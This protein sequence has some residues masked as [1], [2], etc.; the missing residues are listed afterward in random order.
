MAQV[1]TSMYNALGTRPK[2]IGEYT[3]ELDMADLRRQGMQQ[4]AL[5]LQTG[6]MGLQDR[7]RA[8]READTIRNS[9]SGLGP[10]ATDEQRINALKSTGLQGGF[11]QADALEKAI[12]ERQKTGAEVKN[13]DASTQKTYGEAQADA[14]KRYRGALDYV[15]TPQG[16]QRW[17][18]AQYGD[19]VLGQYMA[20]TLG[21]LEQAI[22]RIPTDPQ[23]F[24]QWRQ[25]AALGME[26]HM[27]QK[28]LEGAA[29]AERANQMLVPDPNN[30]GK[31]IPNAPLINAKTQVAQAGA[32]AINNYGAPV[33]GVD[34]EGKPVFFQP[35]KTGGA[36]SIVP[37]VRPPKDPNAEKPLTEGQG[38]ATTFAARMSDA[39]RVI[40]AMEAAGVSGSDLRTM[41]AGNAVTNA[42]ASTEGQQYRQ[43]QE[44]W[45]TANLRKESG[46]AIPKDEMDKDI[47]KWFPK[48]N[49]KKEVRDQKSRARKVAEQGMLVQAGPGAKQVQGILDRS[50]PQSAHRPAADIPS[51]SDDA[52]YNALPSGATFIGPDGKQRR[53]P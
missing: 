40:D 12:L 29:Q 28:R 31:F 45:V 13:K 22:P 16:A 10:Q 42:M 14:L 23:A 25:Q 6:Q 4:N 48:L 7:Q 37:G 20:A 43:A 24:R 17:L 26:K 36:P 38:V 1:D 19:P 46:A 21:P 39:S 51:I 33:A 52:G 9:L 32:S 11:S 47:A 41:A 18:Q 27:E 35:T 15:D 44:N 3:A 53:K 50:A 34:A 8:M 5:A 30:P 2:S 49:D